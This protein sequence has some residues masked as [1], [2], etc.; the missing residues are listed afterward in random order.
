MNL[1][2]PDGCDRHQRHVNSFEN[3]VVLDQDVACGADA[4]C[5]DDYPCYKQEPAEENSHL[6]VS[7][8]R[9]KSYR[10][11]VRPCP[12]TRGPKSLQSRQFD[13]PGGVRF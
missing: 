5:N 13:C 7:A 6:S 9:V 2:V 11:E 1:T 4:G 8:A 3:R 10:P 12:S